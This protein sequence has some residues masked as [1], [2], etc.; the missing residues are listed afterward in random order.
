MTKRLEITAVRR[1]ITRFIGDVPPA[2]SAREPL[3]N[4]NEEVWGT[5][6]DIIKSNEANSIQAQIEM[7]HSLESR[8]SV[9]PPTE[10]SIDL[11][12]AAKQLGLQPKE[13]FTKTLA[14]VVSLS[15]KLNKK[16][17]F[18]FDRKRSR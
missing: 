2:T 5:V 1:R 6:A 12:I 4:Q 9:D 11:A 3:Q 13:F 14:R 16:L 18:I 17:T 10:S 7:A 8:T 15:Q